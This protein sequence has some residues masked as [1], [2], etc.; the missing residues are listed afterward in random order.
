[1]KK[2]VAVIIRQT[3]FNT[4]RNKEGLRMCVGATLKDNKVTVVFL[5]TGVFS[6]AKISPD[7]IDAPDLER[8]YEAFG[9]MKIRLLAEK[10]AV[11]QYNV[12]LRDSVETADIDEIAG[13]LADSDVVVPW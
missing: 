9:I 13:I 10:A 12:D 4:V 1:M 11:S 7:S 3:P 5:G 8:E 2:N 6:A